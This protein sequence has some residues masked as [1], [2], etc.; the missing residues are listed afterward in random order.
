MT[1]FPFLHIGKLENTK[2]QETKTEDNEDHK[3]ASF[4]DLF[5]PSLLLC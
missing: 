1:F 3:E 2:K 4:C 5:S